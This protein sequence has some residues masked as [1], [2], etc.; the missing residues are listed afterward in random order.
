MVDVN[1]FHQSITIDYLME[2]DM[3]V[4]MKKASKAMNTQ[5]SILASVL[6]KQGER[7]AK[8][9]KLSNDVVNFMTQFGFSEEKSKNLVELGMKPEH[10]S[11][12]PAVEPKTITHSVHV[13]KAGNKMVKV[14]NPT[15]STHA[16]AKDFIIYLPTDMLNYIVNNAKALQ[17]LA[18]KCDLE[19]A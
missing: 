12:I 11:V 16:N 2:N 14:I 7:S 9:V 3:T 10:F 18:T 19:N 15:D 1:Y 13:S 17:A 8:P 4:S 6:S 5:A